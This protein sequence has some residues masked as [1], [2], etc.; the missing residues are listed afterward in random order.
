MKKLH[1]VA[2]VVALFVY[3]CSDQMNPVEPAQ[4]PSEAPDFGRVGISIACDDAMIAPGSI[5]TASK[6]VLAKDGGVVV[7]QGT[8]MIAKKD[9]V[10]YKDSIAYNVSLTIPAGALPYDATIS[11]SIDKSSF[12]EDGT[13]TFGPHPL[14]F[15][16]P[17]QLTL[18]ATNIDFVKKNQTI[19]FYY[20]NNGV[21]EPM[22][23]SYGSYAKKS[24]SNAVDAGAQVPHFSR[25]AFGR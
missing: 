11:I 19:V 22:P 23:D 14:A 8:Y 7:L 15:N 17:I 4:M 3:G 9:S 25:Y 10:A 24:G 1:F 5:I 21:M 18:H 6:L 12:A 20:L 2:A 13:I 16:T